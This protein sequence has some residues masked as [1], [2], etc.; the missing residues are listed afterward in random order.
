[1]SAW[2]NINDRRPACGLACLVAWDGSNAYK[3][4]QI[5]RVACA[6]EDTADGWLWY[7]VDFGDYCEWDTDEVPTHWMPLPAPPAKASAEGA[8]PARQPVIDGPEA[9]PAA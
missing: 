2:I 5:N 9:K 1:M 6:I 3:T 8:V 7:E 4:P